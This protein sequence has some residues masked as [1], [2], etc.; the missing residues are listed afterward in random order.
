MV[1]ENPTEEQFDTL[2][3]NGKTLVD[4]W[5]GWCGPCRSQSP[6]AERLEHETDINL[7]KIDVDTDEAL[8]AKF[9][10]SSIPTLVLYDGGK[11]IKQFIG[12]T[13]LEELKSAFGL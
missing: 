12:L 8:T 7:I 11:M 1:T 6:I 5:A 2:I 10:V 4:F 9:G 3:K 13:S